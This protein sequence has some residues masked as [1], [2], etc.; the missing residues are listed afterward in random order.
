MDCVTFFKSLAYDMQVHS[1]SGLL[2]FRKQRNM[3]RTRSVPV[4]SSKG[5]DEPTRGGGGGMV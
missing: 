1:A 4:L 2:L 3:T 5:T